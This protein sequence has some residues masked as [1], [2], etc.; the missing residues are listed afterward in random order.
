M[1]TNIDKKTEG[2]KG[3]GK[4]KGQKEGVKG[5]GKRKGQINEG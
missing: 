2:A 3:R 4:M 1:T 5:R